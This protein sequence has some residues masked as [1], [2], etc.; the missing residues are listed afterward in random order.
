MLDTLK[1]SEKLKSPFL[2]SPKVMPIEFRISEYG[3]LT[4]TKTS[5]NVGVGVSIKHGEKAYKI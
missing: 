2:P 5:S 3:I 1:K 4:M